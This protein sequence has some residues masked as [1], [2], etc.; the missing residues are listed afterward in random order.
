MIIGF[1]KKDFRHVDFIKSEIGINNKTYIFD[2]FEGVKKWGK[3]FLQSLCRRYFK[4][5]T[6]DYYSLICEDIT[7]KKKG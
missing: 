1:I 7:D 5:S 6:L 4:G 3:F 2:E